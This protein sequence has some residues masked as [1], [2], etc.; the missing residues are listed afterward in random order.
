MTTL[1]SSYELRSQMIRTFDLEEDLR[2][3]PMILKKVQQDRYAQNLYAAMCNMRWQKFE[4][5]PLLKDDIWSCTWRY[6]GGI[7]A[8]IREEG[9]YLDWYCTGIRG[10]HDMGGSAPEPDQG[11]VGEGYVTDEIKSDLFKLGWIILS[12]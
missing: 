8:D 2:N 5:V 7:I 12:E 1:L 9:D 11:Y 6:A 10:S 4:V 3:S